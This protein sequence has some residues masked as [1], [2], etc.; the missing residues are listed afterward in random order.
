MF[1]ITSFILS[2]YINISNNYYSKSINLIKINMESEITTIK[3]LLDQGGVIGLVS[4]LAL[5]WNILDKKFGRKNN[6]DDNDQEKEFMKKEV[7]L[8]LKIENI[9][10]SHEE[11]VKKLE[12]ELIDLQRTLQEKNSETSDIYNERIEDLKKIISDY[13][14]LANSTLQTLEKIKFLSNWK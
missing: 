12:F 1:F 7:E 4:A 10:N 14:D 3:D 2:N 13:H 6:T 8:L 9:K 5:I 11:K